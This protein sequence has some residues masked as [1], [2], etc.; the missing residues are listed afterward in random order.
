M[1]YLEDN[2]TNATLVQLQDMMMVIYYL[3]FLED[4]NV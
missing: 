3:S 4:L 2:E 1:E